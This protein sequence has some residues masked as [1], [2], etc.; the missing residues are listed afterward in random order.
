MSAVA[1][2]SMPSDAGKKLGMKPCGSVP[3]EAARFSM[4]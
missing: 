2:M 4:K 3:S 1:T